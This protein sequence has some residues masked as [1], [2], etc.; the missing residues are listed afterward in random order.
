MGWRCDG[1]A[2]RSGAWAIQERA[3]LRPCRFNARSIIRNCIQDDYDTRLVPP[4]HVRIWFRG[5][6]Y[7][8]TLLIPD[9]IQTI[10]SPARLGEDVTV[11]APVHEGQLELRRAE[12][13]LGTHDT[14]A[15]DQQGY[16]DGY[17]AKFGYM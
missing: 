12:L 1:P 15:E 7:E 3:S 5:C 14:F 16:Y 2:G 11:D 4:E 6:S 17:L 9:S 10:P 13:T 8:G